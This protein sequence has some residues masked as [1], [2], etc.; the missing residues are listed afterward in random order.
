MK[1]IILSALVLVI[2]VATMSYGIQAATY[3]TVFS[4][5]MTQPYDYSPNGQSAITV[6]YEPAS[7]F[8]G[9]T[10]GDAQAATSL[11]VSNDATGS[12]YVNLRS[13]DNEVITVSNSTVSNNTIFSGYATKSGY[14]YAKEVVHYAYRYMPNWG[15]EDW[16][17]TYS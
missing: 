11:S 10:V 14:H 3:E 2:L 9:I 5:D 8:L 16:R 7:K 17:Y 6:I 13:P 4:W 12:A 15:A 1:R